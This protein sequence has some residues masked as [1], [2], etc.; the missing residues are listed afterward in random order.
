MCRLPGKVCLPLLGAFL[1]CVSIGGCASTDQQPVETMLAE[2]RMQ[3]RL[4]QID[5]QR[6]AGQF[7]EAIAA[8]RAMLGEQGEEPVARARVWH[9]LGIT[10]GRRADQDAESDSGAPSAADDRAEALNCSLEAIQLLDGV[11]E[12]PPVEL[13]TA[14]GLALGRC[15]RMLGQ[16]DGAIAAYESLLERLCAR[17]LTLLFHSR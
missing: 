6:R 12:A 13:T 11:P 10:Y 5:R 8:Y 16:A 1:L 2:G 14:V 15:H 17:L 3:L 9:E 4:N 7:E